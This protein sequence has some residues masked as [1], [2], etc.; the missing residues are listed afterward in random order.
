MRVNVRLEKDVRFFLDGVCICMELKKNLP[1]KQHVLRMR[2]ALAIDW[3]VHPGRIIVW[4]GEMPK[5][6]RDWKEKGKEFDK[7]V[8]EFDK[9]RL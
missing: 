4:N 6:L 1:T 8:K 5:V 7:A 3:A 9:A 2:A